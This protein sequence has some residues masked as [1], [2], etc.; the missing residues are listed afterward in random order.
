MV[1]VLLSFPRVVEDCYNDNV[2]SL[3]TPQGHQKLLHYPRTV[4][5]I[6]PDYRDYREMFRYLCSQFVG[7]GSGCFVRSLVS[8]G[9]KFTQG[10]LQKNPQ[11]PSDKRTC[12][13]CVGTVHFILC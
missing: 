4:C 5:R 6:E 8:S 3:L 11:P 12:R 1:S 13:F 7:L 9:Q 2:P 10:G